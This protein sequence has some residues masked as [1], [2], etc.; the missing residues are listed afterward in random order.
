MKIKR[1]LVEIFKICQV[2][3]FDVTILVEEIKEEF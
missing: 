3:E 1:Y 2:L